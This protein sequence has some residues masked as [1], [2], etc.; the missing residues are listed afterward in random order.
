MPYSVVLIVTRGNLTARRLLVFA[1]AFWH[2]SLALPCLFSQLAFAFPPE[3]GL[4]ATAWPAPAP[5]ANDAT[6]TT[7]STRISFKARSS[8]L[9]R[10]GADRLPLSCKEHALPVIR[11]GERADGKLRPRRHKAKR[12][13]DAVRS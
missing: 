10:S 6:T 9:G 3:F 5:T 13:G 1:C 7:I 12:R 11:T 2:A 8:P 4:A